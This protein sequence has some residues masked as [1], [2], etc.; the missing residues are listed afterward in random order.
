MVQQLKRDPEL[1]T[2]GAVG[3]NDDADG[4]GGRVA[5]I[6]AAQAMVDQSEEDIYIALKKIDLAP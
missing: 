3:N 5:A 6:G 4:G 1:S 2:S